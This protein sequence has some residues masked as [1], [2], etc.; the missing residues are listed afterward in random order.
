MI[1][2]E[3][4]M[5]VGRWVEVGKVYELKKVYCNDSVDVLD[6]GDRVDAFE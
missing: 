1:V 6:D 4:E 5:I 2:C 3:W